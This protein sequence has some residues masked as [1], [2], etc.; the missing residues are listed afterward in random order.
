MVSEKDFLIQFTG[1]KLGEHQFEY[2]I[3]NDFFDIFD[4]SEFNSANIQ[5][6]ISMLKKTTMLELQLSHKGTINVPCDVTNDD[7]DLPIEGNLNLLVKFGDEFNND[8]DELLILPHGEFQLNVIQ[9][10]YEM[11]ALSVPYKRI[12]PDIAA[13]YEEEESDGELDFLDSD[14]LEMINEEDDDDE[15]NDNET[16]E[17]S[18]ENNDTDPR[19]DKLKQLLTDK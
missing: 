17:N 6:S 14:D 5:V 15:L 11:I 9:Y 4:Y 1:L 12:H 19:W 7:F 3:E 16:D 10:I 2:H 13:D 18:D 8:S